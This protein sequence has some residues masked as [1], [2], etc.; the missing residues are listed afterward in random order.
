MSLK[1]DNS[2]WEKSIEG[3]AYN[4]CLAM[5]AWDG[6]IDDELLVYQVLQALPDDV[7]EIIQ[8]AALFIIANASF[9]FCQ[10]CFI[11]N[12][13]KFL[14]ILRFDEGDTISTRKTTIAHEIAHALRFFEKQNEDPDNFFPKGGLEEEKGADDLCES[15]GFG[16]SYSSYDRFK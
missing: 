6:I 5:P 15:W 7:R 4:T 12:S 2:E 1:N 16:R 3:I 9:V 8:D 13:K 10:N 11:A 14:I